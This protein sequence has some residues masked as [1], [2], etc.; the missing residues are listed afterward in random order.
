[1][2]V[3]QVDGHA[4]QQGHVALG[5]DVYKRQERAG[6]LEVAF[7]T[8]GAQTLVTLEHSGWDGYDDPA[9]ARHDYNLSLIHI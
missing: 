8:D 2:E 3:R 5:V 7:A 6:R 4:F 1:M 9:G